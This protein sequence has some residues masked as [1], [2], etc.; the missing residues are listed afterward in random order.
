[1]LKKLKQRWNAETPTFWKYV[2][3]LSG[4]VISVISAAILTVTTA[5]LPLPG[6]SGQYLA[7]MLLF[8]GGITA[9]AGTRVK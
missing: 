9:F 4:I 7:I 5:G 2:R 3:N 6:N 8:A 1:M